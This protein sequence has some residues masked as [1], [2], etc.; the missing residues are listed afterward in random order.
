MSRYAVSIWR[1]SHRVPEVRRVWQRLLQEYDATASV[2]QSPQYVDYLVDTTPPGTLDILTVADSDRDAT[3]GVV[4]VQR[5]TVRMPFKFGDRTLLTLAVDGLKFPGSKL[6]L[7]DDS[8]ALDSVFHTVSQNY[9]GCQAIEMESVPAGSYLW[10]Y[11]RGSPVVERLYYNHVLYGLREC[12]EVAVPR[13]IEEYHRRL[14][15][16]QR[17]NLARQERLLETHL[18][19]ALVLTVVDSRDSLPLLFAA[20]QQ[21]NMP[22]RTTSIM[23]PD[24]YLASCDH[25]L[26][27][28]YVLTAGSRTIG[29]AVGI[30]S[31]QIY[32]IDRFYYDKSLGRFSPGTTLWQ[33]I[34]KDLITEGVFTHVD[35]GYG[36]PS[37]KYTAINRIE[38]KGTV[39]LL[40]RSVA[41]R[42]RMLA[43]DAFMR[44]RHFARTRVGG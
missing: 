32:H 20:M 42:C 37:Y 40:R 27:L 44:A 28:C 30:K 5:S 8:A 7:P 21:L 14:S 38:Q 10:S 31:R 33:V 18:G 4:P 35:M 13:S 23:T 25:G 43:H 34:L 39:L 17:Y 29:F 24:D 1:G 6:L 15:R 3:I 2:Y 19:H 11:L 26:L 16:K 12:H 9:P 41:N 22:A 36:T